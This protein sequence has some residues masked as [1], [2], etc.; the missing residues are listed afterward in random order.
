MI[1]LTA[2]VTVNTAMA[3]TF[4]NI[5]IIVVAKPGIV[6]HITRYDCFCRNEF[7]IALPISLFYEFSISL[8]T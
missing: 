6:V 3:A 8:V 4:V 5:H 1:T 7:H 2:A